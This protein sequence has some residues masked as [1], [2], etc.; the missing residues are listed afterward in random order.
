M[1]F[2][3]NDKEPIYLQIIRHVKQS[4]VKGDLMPGDT[5]PS[6]RELAEILKVNPNTVQRA[7]KEMESME[8]INTVRNF[9]SSITTNEEIL[10]NIKEELINE[11]LEVFIEN[12]K[13][14]NVSKNEV[15][16]IINE[17]Y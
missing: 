14:I 7:Y 10:K 15:I 5:I 4:I 8:M 3:V 9:P 6:R 2:L 13:A 12:M 16:E 1:N 17:R 11:S